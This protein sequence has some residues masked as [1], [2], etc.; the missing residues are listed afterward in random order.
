VIGARGLKRLAT[1]FLILGTFFNPLGFDLLWAAVQ[2]LLGSYWLTSLC[3]YSV[4]AA[5]FTANF[6]ILR[7]LR[8]RSK[9][10]E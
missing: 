1:L 5:C 3:F 2:H 7:W 10:T 6:L 8:R 9:T 4:S